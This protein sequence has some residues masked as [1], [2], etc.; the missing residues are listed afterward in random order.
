MSEGNPKTF[1]S[2]ASEDKDR[3]VVGLAER[4]RADGVDAWLDQWEMGPGDSLV[5]RIF[6]EGI[7]EADVFVIV[8][9]AVSVDKPWVREELNA[10]VVQRIEGACKLIPI[11]LDGVTVP[12]VLKSTV[13][14]AIT[15]S[16]SYDYEYRRIID[17]IFGISG[18]PPL[19]APPAYATA[20][21]LSGLNRAD[22]SVLSVICQQAIDCEGLLVGGEPLLMRTEALGLS[23]D[24]VVESLLALEQAGMLEDVRLLQGPKVMHVELRWLGLL[25]YL[26]DTQPDLGENQQN[27]IG[28][29]INDKATTWDIVD[30]AKREGLP[31][32]VVEALLARFESRSLLQIARFMGNHTEVRNVSPLLR[33]ELEW[34]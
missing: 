25:R 19:G 1:I 13:W 17:A 3:F 12:V 27:L 16:E 15:D 2:H 14:Q 11:V 9:S 8:L 33:R 30:L 5:D 23:P 4:L 7:G 29:L 34:P 24:A 28:H 22:S 10:A 6:N 26:D 21:T 32:L 18:R 31:R 20:T